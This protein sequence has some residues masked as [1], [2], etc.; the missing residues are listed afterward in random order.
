MYTY[1]YIYIYTDTFLCPFLPI[2]SPLLMATMKR[3]EPRGTSQA[4]SMNLKAAASVLRLRII[5]P[6][7]KLRRTLN[8]TGD[9]WGEL[10]KAG[11]NRK[12]D[13]ERQVM[14]IFEVVLSNEEV[15]WD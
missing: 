14:V 3:C 7:K 1:I 6:R 10:G 13:E 2:E 12:K 8:G 5:P 11:S 4:R 15:E 9:G